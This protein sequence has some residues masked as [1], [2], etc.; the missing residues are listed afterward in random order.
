MTLALTACCVK[1]GKNGENGTNGLAGTNGKNGSS[2]SAL[3]A[4]DGSGALLK[5]TDGTSVFISNG[6][7]GDKGD[8]GEQGQN[9]Q[10]ATPVQMVKLCPMIE[11]GYPYSFPEYAFLISGKYYATYST[12]NIAW[13]AQLY[14]GTYQ[15]TTTGI[16][17]QFTVHQDG[18]I[19]H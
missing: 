11:S 5:C 17:C 14:P 2:C 19:T 7:K 8:Q 15:T 4:T 18:T 13:T 10:D 1:N 6:Q 16:N 3:P 12:N 9:G